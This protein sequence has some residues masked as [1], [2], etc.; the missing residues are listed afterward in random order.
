[1]MY[2]LDTNV[3]IDATN[4]KKI[5]PVVLSHFKKVAASDII[6]PSIVVAELEYGA[7][8]S[9]DYVRNMTVCKDFMKDFK[10]IPFTEKDAEFYGKI[11]QQLARDGTP[12]GSNDML[13]AASAL[14]YNAKIITHN[15]IIVIALRSCVLT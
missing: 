11:R 1:M 14:M 3:I 7:Q 12:I 9:T 5:A 6:V 15:V 2:C 10:I 4:N 8:H 13:I